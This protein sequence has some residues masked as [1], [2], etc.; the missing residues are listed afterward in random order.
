MKSPCVM[1]LRRIGIILGSSMSG[2]LSMRS[3]N[4]HTRV[5]VE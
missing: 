1:D 5:G 2:I 4:L 3:N